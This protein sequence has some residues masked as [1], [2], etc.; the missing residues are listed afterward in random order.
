M[1]SV[2]CFNGISIINRLNSEPYK[3]SFVKAIDIAK[4]YAD[5]V[6]IKNNLRFSSK[7]TDVVKI[8]G[9][10]DKYIELYTNLQCVFGIDGILP[11][12]YTE[13]YILYNTHSK[14]AV[15]DFFDIFHERIAK[16][17]Y[18]FLK[19]HDLSCASFPVEKSLAGK[20]MQYLSGYENANSFYRTIKAY[21]PLQTV[22]S[23]HN[24][25]WNSN[26]SALGLKVLLRDFFNLPIRVEEFRGRILEV[27]ISDQSRIGTKLGKYNKLNF[28]AIL[29]HKFYKADDG[30]TV[31]VG[32]LNYEQ[33][34]SFLPKISSKDKPFSNF[35]KLKELIRLYVPIGITVLIKILLKKGAVKN[36]YLNGNYALN[37][38][39]F[40][41]GH[42]RGECYSEFI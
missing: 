29:D 41:V 26:R 7:Y 10:K 12:N 9:V 23:A 27:P 16:V 24:L 35:A 13:E 22:I 8:E 5:T 38:N 36:T 39:S 17:Q 34:L 3:F 33:Y 1:T 11:D 21:I 2:Q 31:T 32:E 28:S 18:K 20:L 19:R 14:Q 4:S 15:I 30:I 42:N 25:F 40:I 6:I 37:K